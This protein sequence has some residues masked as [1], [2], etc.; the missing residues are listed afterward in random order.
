[1]RFFKQKATVQPSGNPASRKLAEATIQKLIASG[2]PMK[3]AAQ[4]MGDFGKSTTKYFR[5]MQPYAAANKPFDHLL[6]SWTNDLKIV[7]MQA[8][9]TDIAK[10][11][12]IILEYCDIIEASC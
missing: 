9:I 10:Q 8:G 1:M 11:E 5:Q 2:L 7:L 6:E 4:V 3:V 12:E